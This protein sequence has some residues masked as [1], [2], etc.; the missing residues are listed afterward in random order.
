MRNVIEEIRY[1][2]TTLFTG[3]FCDGITLPKSLGSLHVVGGTAM[4]LNG[5]GLAIEPSEWY[6]NG[7]RAGLR[8]RGHEP[9]AKE[10]L[11]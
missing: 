1:G 7:R 11:I 8:R 10:E 4:F 5:T 6:P 2:S 3:P 9:Q